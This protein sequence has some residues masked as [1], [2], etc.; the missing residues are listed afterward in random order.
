MSLPAH[1]KEVH[2]VGIGGYGMSAL[3]FILLGKGY[4]VSGSDI[5]ASALTAALAEKGA[6][7]LTC[8]HSA[9]NL[10]ETDLV[11]YSTAIS[12]DNPEL[13]EARRRGLLLWHRSELLA[14]LLNSAY[15][16]A[17]AGAHGKT[18]T[19][20]MLAL[21]L[22]KA[23]LDPT[24][25][26]GGVLPAFKS[27]ARL[28]KSCYLVAE[29]DESDSSFTRYYPK[30]AVVTGIE[31]DHLEHYN[32]DYAEL[33]KA[34]QTFLSHLEE[35]HTAVLCAGDPAL[36]KMAEGLSCRLVWYD[37]E[38]EGGPQQK[39][40]EEA[41]EAL[42]AAAADVSAAA[43]ADAASSASGFT[44][45]FA[46]P[47]A[48]GS[49]KVSAADP[50]RPSAT[51]TFPAA[52]PAFTE[53][54]PAKD[55]YLARHLKLGPAGS[56]FDLYHNYT[57]IAPTVTL[58]A[59]G[60]HNVQNATAALAAAVALN[61]E[62]AALASAL[63]NFHGAKRRFEVIGQVA[64]ITVIDDYAHHPTEIKT[65]LETANLAGGRVLCLFQPH[66]YSRTATF[67]EEFATAFAKASRLYL[68]A[69][70][71]ASEEPMAGISALSLAGRITALNP[72]LPVVQNDDIFA[73]EAAAAADARPGDIII[74]MGAGDVTQSAPRLLAALKQKFGA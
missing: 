40:E 41:E 4:Q 57:L 50:A 19:T 22:E 30:L 21:L 38:E 51:D 2:F 24:A 48:P 55:I 68:H 15:G 58:G 5:R 25:I 31:A 1:I 47:R 42:K 23:G 67:F 10:K 62:P 18:T 7:L 43:K 9:A 65:T 49:T 17:V 34:Y 37:V 45:A 71:P 60:L 54:G 69:I 66:R 13:K 6:R 39:A 35:T 11:I 46:S 44:G 64:G 61:L 72:G 8:G 28:G 20:A 52:G 70:Y 14:A 3:A 26:I 16:I 29:A 32:N 73:L 53:P 27:N 63:I 12:F 33:K 59:P 36:V 74:T 56:T